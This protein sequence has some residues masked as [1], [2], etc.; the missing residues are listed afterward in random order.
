MRRLAKRK[1][2]NV[3]HQLSGKHLSE[4]R[5]GEPDGVQSA[6]APRGLDEVTVAAQHA[7]LREELTAVIAEREL[8]RA[9]G[10]Q[11]IAKA[12]ELRAQL[13]AVTRERDALKIELHRSTTR[14][15]GHE[16]IAS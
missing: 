1:L 3:V 16:D 15:A 2:T 10:E 5:R 6:A 7:S 11:W 12:E 13:A 14:L 4:Q 9:D 8:F